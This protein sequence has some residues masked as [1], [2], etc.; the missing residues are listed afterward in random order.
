MAN[1]FE[2][3]YHD[4]L[5][6]TLGEHYDLPSDEDEEKQCIRIQVS[7][8]EEICDHEEAIDNDMIKYILGMAG[9][10]E[11]QI[12]CAFEKINT[13]KGEVS[14]IMRNLK[15]HGGCIKKV[16]SDLI[17]KLLEGKEVP[18]IMSHSAPLE[19]C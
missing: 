10:D 1:M 9:L 14:R 13:K 2:T 17:E 12:I 6:A 3:Q 7:V 19:K 8:V 15:L 4:M 18:P 11:E 5:V 16:A